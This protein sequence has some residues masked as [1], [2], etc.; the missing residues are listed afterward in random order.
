M[1]ADGNSSNPTTS[2]K[3]QLRLIGYWA[4]KEDDRWPEPHDFIDED[5]SKEELVEVADYLKRGMVAGRYMGPSKCRMCGRDNGTLELTDGVYVWPEGLAHYL[6]HHG[7]RL[8]QSFVEH[9]KASSEMW[10]DANVDTSWW[11]SLK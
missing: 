7:V 8:P 3:K 1:V 10:E 9:T 2:E 4:S 11:K 5:W 6:E